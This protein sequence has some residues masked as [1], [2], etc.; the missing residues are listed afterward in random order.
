[1]RDP[2]ENT[3]RRLAA[4]AEKFERRDVHCREC[5]LGGHKKRASRSA[6]LKS[7]REHGGHIRADRTGGVAKHASN[8]SPQ[9]KDGL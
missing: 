7:W 1:M 3:S 2:I 5:E 4:L 6:G 8:S 9:D